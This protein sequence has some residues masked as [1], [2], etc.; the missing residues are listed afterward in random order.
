MPASVTNLLD[1]LP[2][3]LTAELF[4][5]LIKTPE[6]RIER[7]LSDGQVTPEGQWYD[8]AEDEW[9]LLLQGAAHIQYADGREVALTVGDSLLLPAR[10]QHRVSWTTEDEITVWLAVFYPPSQ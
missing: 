5:T 3:S 8:Q 2:S 9:I 1:S 6:L 7:I 4:E 10:C